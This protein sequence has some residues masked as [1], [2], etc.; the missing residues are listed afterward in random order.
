[1]RLVITLADSVL[2]DRDDRPGAVVRPPDTDRVATAVAALAR[3]HETVVIHGNGSLT[4]A[5]AQM[6]LGSPL[7]LTLNDVLRGRR[8]ATLVTH[9]LV[10]TDD[11]GFEHPTTFVGPA[12]P[13]P[14]AQ[15]LARER[16][17]H[18]AEDATGWR[19]VVASPEPVRVLE[20]GT[21]HELLGS[22]VTVICAGGGGVPVTADGDTGALRAVEA[23][24][25]KDLTAALLAEELRA[26]FLLVLTGLPNVYADHGTP[27]RRPVLDATPAE[28]RRLRR[29]AD[30]V[31]RASEAAARFVER[32]GGLAAIGALDAAYE[33][34]HGRSG[35]LVRPDLAFG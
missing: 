1:M 29:P 32:T 31:R 24:V 7:A 13:R 20:A 3:E 26:D 23:V 35:T 25:D 17:W 21:V 11:P 10:R 2:L 6:L 8:I 12:R 19:R 22:G 5:Q 27:G 4:G 33:I 14:E 9:T 30:S 18:V 28:L 15:A 16:G 34:V